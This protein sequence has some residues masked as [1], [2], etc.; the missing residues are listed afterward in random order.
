MTLN[1]TSN[2]ANS[3]DKPN[4]DFL[5]GSAVL[6]SETSVES[7]LYNMVGSLVLLFSTIMTIMFNGSLLFCIVKHKKKQ[8]VRNA[9][10]LV[11]LIV[12]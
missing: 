11:Y 6:D 5:N 7:E 2:S 4:T 9:H 10:Q 12:P 3:G 8:W 1:T